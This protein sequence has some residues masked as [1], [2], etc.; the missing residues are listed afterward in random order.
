MTFFSFL[1]SLL[2]SV[3]CILHI[4]AITNY[5]KIEAIHYSNVLFSEWSFSPQ[6]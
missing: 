5:N 1:L 3:P 6:K 4:E 2:F